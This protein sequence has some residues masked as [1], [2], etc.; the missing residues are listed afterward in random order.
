MNPAFLKQRKLRLYLYLKARYNGLAILNLMG[1]PQ[2]EI[3]HQGR[4]IAHI[5]KE[6]YECT[7]EVFQKGSLDETREGGCGRE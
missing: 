5:R 1:A 2:Y 7:G 6:W 3:S 4:R